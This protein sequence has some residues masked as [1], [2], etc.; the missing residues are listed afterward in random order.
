[1]LDHENSFELMEVVAKYLFE[2][3]DGFREMFDNL[4]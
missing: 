4:G 3:K 1:M 2:N